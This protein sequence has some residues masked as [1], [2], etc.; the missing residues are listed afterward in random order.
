MAGWAIDE[1]FQWY[2]L[3]NY[4]ESLTIDH[5]HGEQSNSH[6]VAIGSRGLF[7]FAMPC[8][9]QALLSLN[10][11]QRCLCFTIVREIVSL[12]ERKKGKKRRGEHRER[13]RESVLGGEYWKHFYVSFTWDTRITCTIN[14]KFEI[15]SII[16]IC[17]GACFICSFLRRRCQSARIRTAMYDCKFLMTLRPFLF[18]VT[19]WQVCLVRNR[20]EKLSRFFILTKLAY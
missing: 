12:S 6:W 18:S 9:I 2:F 20:L 17:V 19:L 4:V 3:L 7:F 13:E 10:S 15:A 14:I 8:H 11:S 5:A 1:I 16:P